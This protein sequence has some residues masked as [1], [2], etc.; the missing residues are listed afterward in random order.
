MSEK[1]KF[2]DP[3][4]TYFT[5]STIV[6]WVDVFSRPEL[7]QI[8]IN[9]L[10]YCQKEKGLRIHGWCLMPSHLHMM[11][12][13]TK[14]PLSGIIRDFKSHTSK[15]IIK[16]LDTVFESRRHWMLDLFGEVGDGLRRISDHKVWQ[17]GNHPILLDKPKLLDE[18]LEYIHNNP[19]AEEIVCEPEQYL[20]SSARDYCTTNLKGLL[21]IDFI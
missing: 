11:C 18:K 1:Y 3:G 17:D 10:R 6:G 21:E 20:Y 13:T 16:A 5:T 2:L 8:I 4:G 19:V 15:E 7:K 9:S 14:D 12:S